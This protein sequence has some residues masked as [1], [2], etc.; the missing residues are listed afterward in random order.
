MLRETQCEEALEKRFGE[1]LALEK[2]GKPTEAEIIYRSLLAERKTPGCY[3]NLGV[4]LYG[5]SRI[6]E[7]LENYL[8]ALKINPRYALA[9]YNLAYL[10]DDLHIRYAGE[11]RNHYE[12]CL[13]INPEYSDALYN[14]ALLEGRLGHF[15]KAISMLKRF[16]EIDKGD[17]KWHDLSRWSIEYYEARLAGGDHESCKH[18]LDRREDALKQGRE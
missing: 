9:H 6:E 18:L 7:A 8:E 15:S 11:A 13:G 1:A 17:T 16:L 12:N 10:F 5:K 2:E 3:V 14:Y 4:V